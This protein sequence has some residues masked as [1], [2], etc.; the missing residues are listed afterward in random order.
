MADENKI[1]VKKEYEKLQKEF[2][3]PSF[4]KFRE[5]F[6]VEKTAEKE[7]GILVREIRRTMGEKISGYLHLFETLM[8]PASPP[9]FVFSFL[10]SSSEKQR[11]EIKEYYME[12]SK[13]QI[14]MILLDTVFEKKKEGEFVLNVYNQWQTLKKKIHELIFEFEKEFEKSAEVKEK[15]YFG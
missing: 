1:D 11:K 5:D 10:K 4:D 15:S 7:S 14:K 6:D 13:I 9:V 8:N 3:W 2:D 12:L